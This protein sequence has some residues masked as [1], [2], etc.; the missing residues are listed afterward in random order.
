MRFALNED[1]QMVADAARE[2]LG[3]LPGARALLEGQ[4]PV[5][6]GWAGMVEEQ[7]W[8][9]LMV[10]EDCDGFGFD[11]V[12][13]GVVLEELGRS[14]VPAPFLGTAWATAA[15]L[16]CPV[17]EARDAALARIAA[18]E[19]AAVCWDTGVVVDGEAATQVV[20]VRE[21]GVVLAEALNAQKHPALDP[22]RSLAAVELGE[23][24]PMAGASVVPLVRARAMALLACECVGVAE[25]TLDLAVD[26]AKVR[27][28]FGGP[29]GRFQAVQHL[30]A[31]ML[32]HVE[33]ARSA[34][35]YAAWFTCP[36]ANPDRTTVEALSAG[37]TALCTATE[38]AMAC[39]GTSIQ[40]HG[41]IGFTWEHACHLYF[42][43]A[44]VNQTLLGE[45]KRHRA[46]LAARLLGAI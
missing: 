8:P 23:Q 28:Q 22:S 38:A 11:Q 17:G 44:R 4:E 29:I 10:P 42:K 46:E 24:Q 43:R 27:S 21:E 20:C 30:C 2:Y 6:E 13:A 33:S 37:R 18:G 40:V 36:Q 9:A 35:W 41:G 7:S 1:Q 12:S 45:P 34:A 14:L 5:P 31:D 26:Y 32:V 39:A 25:A 19:P 16:E 3:R 15:L